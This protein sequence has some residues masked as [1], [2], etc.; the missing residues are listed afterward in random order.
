VLDHQ[1]DLAL[2]RRLNGAVL[3]KA[4]QVIGRVYGKA[5]RT[6][7]V[8]HTA[9]QTPRGSVDIVF[10]VVEVCGRVDSR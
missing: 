8:E 9:T 3:E 2:D 7:R 1:V 4:G 5:G 10:Q 6:V